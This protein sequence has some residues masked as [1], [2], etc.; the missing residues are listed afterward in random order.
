MPLPLFLML[1]CR[2]RLLLVPQ[3][4]LTLLA[5]KRLGSAAAADVL[6]SRISAVDAHQTVL[7]PRGQVR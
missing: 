7:K 3:L 5:A 2:L 1:G 6:D 4:Y